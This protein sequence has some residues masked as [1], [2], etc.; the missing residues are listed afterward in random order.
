MGLANTSNRR[1]AAVIGTD[2]VVVAI[3][4]GK[5]TS[6]V[7]IARVS[8]AKVVIGADFGR[9]LATSAILSGVTKWGLA[10]GGGLAQLRAEALL[11]A[12]AES[13]AS[14]TTGVSL[15]VGTGQSGEL[16]NE[17]SQLEEVL[18]K[19]QHQVRAAK[20]CNLGNIS[21][22]NRNSSNEDTGTSGVCGNSVQGGAGGL[23][24]VLSIG[25]NDHYLG[26]STSSAIGEQLLLGK[27]DTT[28]DASISS[29]LTDG[30]HLVDKGRFVL[31]EGNGQTSVGIKLNKSH[32]SVLRA[33]GEAIG[34]I[35][36]KFLFGSE[37]GAING[38]R[39]IKDQYHILLSGTYGGRAGVRALRKRVGANCSRAGKIKGFAIAENSSTREVG[40]INKDGSDTTCGSGISL[41]ES[42][43]CTAI[44]S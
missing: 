4:G 44:D 8:S 32:G 41:V 30:T 22:G 21:L 39:F 42:C 29:S 18:Y 26:N 36:S 16:I 28:S 5:D 14:R 1:I 25:Q 17:L 37:G 11:V 35:D 34:Q 12:S 19:G 33:K 40:S 23:N 38:T 20:T 13:F 15:N 31:G 2:I 24:I 6:S 9:E 27:N 43:A 3:D 10:L 7:V